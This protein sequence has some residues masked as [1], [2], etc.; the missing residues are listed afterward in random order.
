MKDRIVSIDILRG[1]TVFLMILFHIFMEWMNWTPRD[2]GLFRDIMV[3]F[4]YLAPPFFLIIS[5]MAYFFFISIKTN[6]NIS[7]SLIFFEVIKRSLFIFV[8]TTVLQIGMEFVFNIELTKVIYWSIFQIIGFSMVFF[9]SS[10]FLKQSLRRIL[11]FGLIFLFIF[12]D[13]II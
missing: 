12:L 4:D 9:F 6:E 7:K 8:V 10:L 13:Y 3:F 5:G 11:Y 1:F 2:Y